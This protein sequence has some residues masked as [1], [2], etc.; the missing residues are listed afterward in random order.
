MLRNRARVDRQ[1]LLHVFKNL[2]RLKA[3][4]K[5]VYT[6]SVPPDVEERRRPIGEGREYASIDL[7]GSA[8]AKAP[9][10]ESG[11]YLQPIPGTENKMAESAEGRRVSVIDH[12]TGLHRVMYST[13]LT[14]EEVQILRKLVGVMLFAREPSPE[15]TKEVM[16]RLRMLENHPK[17][18]KLISPYGWQFLWAMETDEIPGPRSRQIGELMVKAGVPMSEEQ[19]LAY[20]G[21]MFWT[22]SREQAVKRWETYIKKNR[23]PA[24][25]GLGVKL[26]CLMEQPNKAVSVV[27][28]M[29]KTLGQ[30]SYKVWIPIILAFNHIQEGKQAFHTYGRMR[31][32]AEQNG[33]RITAEQFDSIA[34]SFLENYNPDM[35]LQV[36]KHMV[37]AGHNAL[38]RQ[39]T[40]TYQNLSQAVKAAQQATMDPETL[41]TISLDYI[42]S[43]PPSVA[44]QYLYSGWML[45]LM[46]MGRT[47]LALTLVADV[48]V[49]Q[50]F[51]PDSI[52]YNWIIQGFLQEDRVDLAVE[53]GMQMIAERKRQI[54]DSPNKPAVTTT[55]KPGR[56]PDDEEKMPVAPATVQTFSI[57]M[58]Y[59]SRRQL[60]DKVAPLYQEMQEC[61]IQANSYIM[62]HLLL[63]LHRIR[64]Y[65]Q[66]ARSFVKLVDDIKVAP[67]FES[68]SIMWT[69]MWR[70]NSSDKKVTGPFLKPRDLFR[71]T[72]QHL[73]KQTPESEGLM[74]DI[75]HSMMKC[76][77][78]ARDLEGALLALHA[79]TSEWG[80]KID[81]T[82]VQECAFGVLRARPYDSTNPDGRPYIDAP[83]VVISAQNIR[84]L[85]FDIKERRTGKRSQRKRTI[86]FDPEDS[87]LASLNTIIMKDL[88]MTTLVQDELR[89]A[90]HD[91][92]LDQVTFKEGLDKILE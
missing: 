66:L 37:F 60:I 34:M 18:L 45:N 39:Q 88:G 17:L 56:V 28:N 51:L 15:A 10:Q 59:Y 40:E 74:K 84:E 22:S 35:G 41:N 4:R 16:K 77:F 48:M 78:L 13:E 92:G 75:W 31:R 12:V 6:E 47:D 58:Q 21:A 82:I 42:K 71:M 64:D 2:A 69:A 26:Y 29:V 72:F 57:L 38:D 67:D 36:Y 86:I 65:N 9:P 55:A 76:F 19:E 33:D 30:V 91:M 1:K 52:H 73:P 49:S 85:G 32:Y 80:L 14:D 63:A 62:N 5:V 53:I 81:Q 44:N 68:F 43:L 7:L 90:R 24:V 87:T 8:G 54:A 27:Q 79:G 89:R 70:F 20:I 46:R 23:S 61:K 25:W 11:H 3:E 83:T 50:G